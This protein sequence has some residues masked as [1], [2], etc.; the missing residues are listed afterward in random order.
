MDGARAAQKALR[1]AL[2][3][4]GQSVH[5]RPCKPPPLLL[6]RLHFGQI[7][8]AAAARADAIERCAADRAVLHALTVS[9]IKVEEQVAQLFRGLLDDRAIGT[10]APVRDRSDQVKEFAAVFFAN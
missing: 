7:G 4:Q 9:R 2:V 3:A 10:F 5:G 8:P 6:H 1:F